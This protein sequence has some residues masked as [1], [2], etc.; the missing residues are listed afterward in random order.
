MSTLS[1]AD[2]LV[3]DENGSLE[4]KSEMGLI[5]RVLIMQFGYSHEGSLS[6]GG[7]SI[8]AC[9]GAVG[10]GGGDCHCSGTCG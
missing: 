9:L 7:G 4:A 5:C 8:H 2:W 3:K 1:I 6:L 10:G